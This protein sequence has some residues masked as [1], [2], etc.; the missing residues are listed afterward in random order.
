MKATGEVMAIAPT[1][2]AALMK[3]VGARRSAW[4]PLMPR[5][6][7]KP[8]TERLHEQNDER[9]FTFSRP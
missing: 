3:A 1:F 6:I 2:E 7:D 8:V 4:T 9:L 5:R